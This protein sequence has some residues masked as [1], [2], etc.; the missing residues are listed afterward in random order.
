MRV[1]ASASAS[2]AK[3][4]LSEVV[5]DALV[6]RIAKGELPEDAVRSLVKH[7]SDVQER[8]PVRRFDVC[9]SGIRIDHLIERDRFGSSATMP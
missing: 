2:A 8:F 1:A 9:V 5:R 7:P 3:P 4:G 6:R